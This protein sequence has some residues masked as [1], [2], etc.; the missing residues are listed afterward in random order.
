MDVSRLPKQWQ[1][2]FRRD[3]AEK[4]ALPDPVPERRLARLLG[5]FIVTGLVFMVLPGTLLGVWNLVGISSQREMAAISASWIQAHGHA[6]FFG[7]VGTFIIGISL[8]A[9]PKFRGSICRSIPIGWLMWAMWGIGVGLR[10]LAGVQQRVHRWEFSVAAT[11]ELIVGVLLVW[12]VTPVGPK[13]KKGQPWETP[14]FAGFGALLLILAWQWM[15][16]AGPLTSTALPLASDRILISLAIWTFGFPVVIGFSAKFFPGLLGTAPARAAGIR[17]AIVPAA[18]AAAGF[19]ADA[20][21]LAA[22]ATSLAVALA[23]W[24]LHVFHPRSKNP[25][26]SGVYERYPHFARLA[27]V[28]LAVSACLGYGV[29]RPGV[30]G[31]SRHAFTVGF[32]STLI[33]S[34]GPRILPSFLNSRELWSPR[35]MRA[36]LL[37]IAAGCSVRVMAEPLAYGGVV[38]AAWKALPVSA[39]AELTAVLLFAFNLAMSM[40][41]PI[42]SW[43]GRKQ[44]SDRM[45]VYWLVSSYPATRRL[46]IEN[47]LVTLAGT[48]KVPKTLSLAEA[49]QAD[50]V[51][52][53]MLVEKLGDFFESRLAAALRK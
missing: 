12:Q 47:G 46:L 10:W 29:S 6:Q 48:D 30:L 33:F 14:V 42:P 53:P 28:W 43:F 2:A 19:A 34:I 8:Y 49:A 9:L 17:A 36:S 27:Y 24:A 37:L 41:T 25:K 32:L 4:P 52:V 22:T 31:A 51:P 1:D 38:A 5:A 40:A 23:I 26:T 44:V 35:L 18:I 15:L 50:G 21:V 20:P 7:W 45:S 11:F 16:A 13:H 39:F 3:L